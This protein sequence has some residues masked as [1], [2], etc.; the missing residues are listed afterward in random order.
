MILKDR[1]QV[2]AQVVDV[3]ERER[4]D[5]GEA[6]GQR[7]VADLV[8]GPAREVV[9]VGGGE[10]AVPQEGPERVEEDR[11]GGGP[12]RPPPPLP[13]PPPRDV[14]RPAPVPPTDQL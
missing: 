9:A 6:L 14:E 2:L 7:L 12:P 13:P 11:A 8:G 1:H 10:H 3:R 5:D 4:I